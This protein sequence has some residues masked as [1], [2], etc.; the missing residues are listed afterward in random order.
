[1]LNFAGLKCYAD[2]KIS[3]LKID[4][5]VN[6]SSIMQYPETGRHIR[7][8]LLLVFVSFIFASCGIQK[9][10]V[11]FQNLPNDTTLTNLVTKPE[12][13][14]IVPGDLLDI[15]V[16]GLDQANTAIYNAPTNTVDDEDGHLVNDDGTIEFIKLGRVKA[17]G[18]TKRQMARQLQEDLVPYVGQN[19]V[20]SVGIKNRHI[21]MMG[22]IAS[23]VM[24]LTQNMTLLDAL[25][26]S[27]DIKD[28]G[29]IK[30]ILVIRS[31]SHGEEKEFKRIDL[32]DN[33]V[34]YSPYF[35]LQP[36]DIVYVEPKRRR[37]EVLQTVSI[38]MS[39]TSFTLLLIDRIFR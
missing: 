3:T 14:E 16:A 29:K 23:K 26:E 31:K 32:R 18:L 34:F 11:Y 17:A 36:D 35:Y 20:V 19:V 39:L 5:S 1:M 8:F 28:Q 21:T 7:S 38:F 37:Q 15:K 22:G 4:D 25:A 13:P 24:P 30:N 10:L 27:G 6:C 12:E 2:R 9:K 33:S